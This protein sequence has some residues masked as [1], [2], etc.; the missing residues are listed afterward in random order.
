MRHSSL[1]LFQRSTTKPLASWFRSAIPTFLIYLWAVSGENAASGPRAAEITGVTRQA[2]LVLLVGW[3]VKWKLTN[4]A[5]G[6]YV[7]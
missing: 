6:W 1:V 7:V 2:G 5:S 3:G 4:G